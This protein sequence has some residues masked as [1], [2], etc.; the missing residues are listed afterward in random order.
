MGRRELRWAFSFDSS[1][2]RSLTGKALPEMGV[3]PHDQ[4]CGT[5]LEISLR[6]EGTACRPTPEYRQ[7][8]IWGSPP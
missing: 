6:R 2:C 4:M 1:L 3:S 8:E 5:R 7:H